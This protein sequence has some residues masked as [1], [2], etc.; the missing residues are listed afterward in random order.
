MIARLSSSVRGFLESI[1][2]SVGGSDLAGFTLL[3]DLRAVDL[4]PGMGLGTP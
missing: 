2:M 3:L 4:D 1:P